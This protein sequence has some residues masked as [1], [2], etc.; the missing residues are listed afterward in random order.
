MFFQ[1]LGYISEEC[2]QEPFNKSVL[3][4]LLSENTVV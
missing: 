4:Y 3:K 2:D 1:L